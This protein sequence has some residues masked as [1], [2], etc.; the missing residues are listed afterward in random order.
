MHEQLLLLLG[1]EGT[2]QTCH[3]PVSLLFLKRKSGLTLRCLLG[4]VSD[5]GVN[6][7]KFNRSR[8]TFNVEHVT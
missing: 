2:L 8:S 5:S 4:R 1:I 3:P 6:E 7:N